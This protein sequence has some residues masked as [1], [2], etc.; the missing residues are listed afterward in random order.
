MKIVL[1]G[2]YDTGKPRVRLL[3]DGMR[4]NGFELIEC[5][6]DIWSGIEDKSQVSSVFSKLALMLR[7]FFRYPSL[8]WRY[9]Q[10]PAHDLVLVSYPGLFDVLVIRCF[11]WLRR[12]PV[13]WDVFISAYDTV[14]DDRR[15]FSV[16]HPVA[17]V[18]W[19][20]EW[21]AVRAADGIFMDTEAHARR[22]ERL[23]RLPD[24]ECGKVWVGAETEKFPA[25]QVAPPRLGEPL[26]VLFYGQFIPLHGIEY[27]VE[28][29]GLLRDEEIDWILIGKGQ[30]TPRIRD[31]LANTPL[32]RLRWLEWVSYPDLITWIQQADICLGIFGTSKKA[33]NV[34]PNKVFQ[35]IAAQKPLITRDS[36]AIRELLRHSPPCVSLIPAGNAN[37]LAEIVLQHTD[38]VKCRTET[39]CHA[40][41]V[42]RIDAVAVGVQFRDWLLTKRDLSN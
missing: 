22:L 35:I 7:L 41:L 14:V 4:K 42:N 34:I 2:T 5:H 29:A 6:A 21:L 31:M 3:I 26:Q 25:S 15:L 37:A 40:D 36:P 38:K 9:L 23:F 13:A 28:A 12:A 11:A 18:L 8:I 17:R 20:L 39:G 16:R 19:G 33:A 1:W 24:G 27:I 10:L 30:E 32:P